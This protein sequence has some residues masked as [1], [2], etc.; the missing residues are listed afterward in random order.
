[1]D[2]VIVIC[3]PKGIKGKQISAALE[4]S[5]TLEKASGINTAPFTNPAFIP[6]PFS[7]VAALLLCFLFS[8]FLLQNHFFIKTES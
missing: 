5:T 3:I 2:R 4:D 8:L 1:M 6:F 7:P